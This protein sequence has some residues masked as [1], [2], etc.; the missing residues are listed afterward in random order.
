MCKP[1]LHLSMLGT[2]VVCSCVLNVAHSV[3]GKWFLRWA[4]MG[5]LLIKS[6]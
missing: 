6:L 1:V 3:A 5:W 4:E 2:M